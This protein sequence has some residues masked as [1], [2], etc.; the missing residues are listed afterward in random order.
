MFKKCLI[1]FLITAISLFPTI[2]FAQGGNHH[3]VPGKPGGPVP[4][5]GPHRDFHSGEVVH[6][7]PPGY[8]SLIVGGLTYLFCEG[9]FYQHTPAGYVVVQPPIGAVVPILPQGYTTIF[10]NGI[11]YS[12]YGYTYYTTTPSGYAV[13]T[14]PV[15]TTPPAAVAAPAPPAAA[16]PVPAQPTLSNPVPTESKT[17][18]KK[19]VFEIY[20]PNGNGSYTVVALRKT[21]KGFLGPQG[22]FYVDHPTVDQLRERY[23]KKP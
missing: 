12:Y 22:E 16:S 7:L 9:L 11:P 23:A 8:I 15:L 17:E 3:G 1:L 19:D 5:G 10:V 20:I 13:V 21:E 4:I 18:E 2:G 6:R 14:P